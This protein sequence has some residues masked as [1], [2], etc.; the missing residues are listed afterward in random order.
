MK[1]SALIGAAAA[2][3]ATVYP[4]A[5]FHGFGD[6]CSNSGMSNFTKD[7]ATETGAY[8]VCVEIGNGASS[9]IFEE[10][11]KQATE[12][13]DKVKA[14]KNLMGAAKFNV[15]G[16][17]QGSLLA[18][19]VAQLC[20]TPTPPNN[21]LTIGS[22]SMGTE[23]IPNC[24]SGIFCDLINKLADSAVY[25]KAAQHLIGPAGYFRNPK[26]MK[27]YI[28][29]SVFLPALNNE[30]EHPQ[31]AFN[32]QRFTSLNG[33][34]MAEFTKDTMIYPKETA[35]FGSHDAE[36]KLIAMEDQPIYKSDAFGLKTQNE[37]GKIKKILI[38]GEHLQFTKA[39]ISNI[40]VPFL[41]NGITEAKYQ[42]L[43]LF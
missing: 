37:A 30:K 3:D 10:F 26:D 34:M 7:I 36:G 17:S 40:F 8:S 13:C 1:F 4:T 14:D 42:D 5:I 15:M 19:Y 41:K 43:N 22:P 12:A 16:L 24:T 25:F 18:R 33:I 11:D 21:L 39:D 23:A 27:D 28:A 20:D 6:Q 9:S 38:D 35:V 32:K 29:D 2:A 31:T